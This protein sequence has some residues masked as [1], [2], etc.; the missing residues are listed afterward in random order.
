M[1]DFKPNKWQLEFIKQL[2]K[3]KGLLIVCMPRRSG[4]SSVLIY[5][6]KHHPELYKKYL[7]SKVIR[8]K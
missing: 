2:E 6:S 4:L 5:L 8:F 1:N 7:D 3:S